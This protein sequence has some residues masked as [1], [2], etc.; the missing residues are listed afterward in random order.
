M[1]N[2]LL[3]P[4]I[5]IENIDGLPVVGAKV[6]VYYTG[7][8]TLAPIYSDKE[9]THQSNP[10][11]TDTLGN[12]TIFADTASF[13]D[14]FVYDNNDQFLFSKEYVAPNSTNDADVPEVEVEAGFGIQV[15]KRYQGNKAIYNVA[16]DQNETA[17][18]EELANKQDKL[19]A[20]ANIEITDQNVINVVQRKE[21]VTETPL[22][23]Q[24]TS[25]RI[26]LYL[27]PAFSGDF[28]HAQDEVIIGGSSANYISKITQN[29]NGNVS[30][31]VG[32]FVAGAN[33]NIA[34]N[35]GNL[36]V[37]VTDSIELSGDNDLQITNQTA[38]KGTIVDAAGL[39]V[40]NLLQ[41]E[42]TDI[43]KDHV[44][45]RNTTDGK[46]ADIETDSISLTNASGSVA[47]SNISN[48]QIGLGTIV[49]GAQKS[50][51]DIGTREHQYANER[52]YIKLQDSPDSTH[53]NN[54][55]L[56]TTDVKLTEYVEGQGATEYSLKSACTPYSGGTGIS[57][58]NHQIS[59]NGDITPYTGSDYITVNNHQISLSNSFVARYRIPKSVSCPNK[60]GTRYT[61]FSQA[62]GT[63]IADAYTFSTLYNT[64]TQK[65]ELELSNDSTRVFYVY[66]DGVFVDYVGA[67]RTKIYESA[68]SMKPIKIELLG[69]GA[70]YQTPLYK[71]TAIFDEYSTG[72]MVSLYIE[73]DYN[74]AINV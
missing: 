27:D 12:V 61:V 38:D 21:L 20:G 35:N 70:G 74:F 41:S 47:M 66:V 68:D 42:Y 63:G 33:I 23:I 56:D 39:Y 67:L 48:P 26:K 62:P 30:A 60:D 24:R 64:S 28:K 7:S 2:Y 45:V 50:S 58:S 9:G 54:L 32:N 8:R 10:A 52:A 16:I 22:K 36:N 49:S 1:I 72:Y 65:Y 71:F 31:N 40:S 19:T 11:I 18:A 59:C 13:Y 15:H 17:T 34:N 37:G 51:I 29:E 25:N 53:T 44:H 43:S 4:F 57:V 14:V 6:Y 55:R 3:D 73:Y 5:Q 46:Y 69:A